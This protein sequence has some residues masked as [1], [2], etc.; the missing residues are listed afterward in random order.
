MHEGGLAHRYLKLG[1]ILVFLRGPSWWVK[2][3]GFGIS[4][5]VEASTALRTME[6]GTRGVMVSEIFGL[7]YPHAFDETVLEAD[8]VAHGALAYTPDMAYGCLAKSHTEC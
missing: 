8:E 6:I 1:N 3:A 5:W 4:K 7:H 2:I